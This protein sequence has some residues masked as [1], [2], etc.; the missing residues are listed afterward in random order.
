MQDAPF[1]ADPDRDGCGA[2][3]VPGRALWCHA[4]DGVRLRLGI[5]PGDCVA[6]KG[7]VLLFPGRTEYLEKYGMT[8][9]ALAARG[10]ATMAIDWRGQGLADRLVADRAIGHVERFG[11]YQ[12]DVDAMVAAAGALS[13]PRPW[14]LIGHS[15]GG[16]IG[17]RAVLNRLPVHAALFTGPM[18]G[19]AMNPVLRQIARLLTGPRHIGG[20]GQFYAPGTGPTTYV[21]EAPFADN[22]LTTDPTTFA[23]LQAQARAHP[24]LAIGGPSLTWLGEALAEIRDLCAA[25][26]PDLPTL[27]MVGGNERIIDVGAVAARMAD[28]R[29]G[30]FEVVAGAEH[31]ILMETPERRAA[32]ID[33]AVALFADN[34][35]G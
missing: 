17:L 7:T 35:A 30:R 25:P 9:S 2:A 16:A 1:F 24:D 14:Y 20:L 26:A 15:M 8:A 34:R 6:A 10:Y 29:G 33:R 18:W 13:L 5:W 4:T 22:L 28:W 12:L 27:T 21:L 3:L 19:I 11:D 23:M 32:A 31:E